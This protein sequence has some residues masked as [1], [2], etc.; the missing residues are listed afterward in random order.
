MRGP[1]GAGFIGGCRIQQAKQLQRGRSRGS[2]AEHGGQEE[3][4]RRR[5]TEERTGT[6]T[7]HIPAGPAGNGRGAGQR[8]TGGGA[9]GEGAAG[10]GERGLLE[11]AP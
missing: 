9:V 8:P 7:G 11:T 6:R 5:G 3:V 4:C 10:R 1:R 2:E